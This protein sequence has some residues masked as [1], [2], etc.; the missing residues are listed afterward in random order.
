TLPVALH[1]SEG[2]ALAGGPVQLVWITETEKN[3]KTFLLEHS[4][5]GNH[6]ESVQNVAAGNGTGQQT[7]TVYDNAPYY[8]LS[9]YRLRQADIDGKETLL[10]VI[11]VRLS[12]ALSDN[13]SVYPNPGN[14]HV[15]VTLK[16]NAF[17]GAVKVKLTDYLGRVFNAPFSTA[18]NTLSMNTGGL[19]NGAYFLSISVNEKSYAQKLVIAR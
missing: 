8:P 14:D 4:A 3:N 13:I 17:G 19:P 11:A 6:W 9:Y 5:D 18:G 12:S 7:Y 2:T 10:S 16:N 1:S 15:T